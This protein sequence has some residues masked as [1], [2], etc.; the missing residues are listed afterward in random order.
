MDPIYAFPGLAILLPAGDSLVRGA[1]NL[2]LRPG[3]SAKAVLNNAPGI[4]MGNV[5]G[6]NTAN[7]LPGP[8]YPP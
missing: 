5:V 3:I 7:T 6:S 4:A 8:G 1:V 2:A